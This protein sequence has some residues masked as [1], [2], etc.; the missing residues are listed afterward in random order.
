MKIRVAM[1]ALACVAIAGSVSA[2]TKKPVASKGALYDVTVTADQVYTGTMEMTIAGGKVAGTMTLTSPTTITGNVAGT[3]KAGTLSLD[4]PYRMTE[5]NC[6]GNV[7]MTIK[8]P[9]KPG[10]ASGTMEAGECG[11]NPDNKT[12][13]TVDL[14]PAVPAKK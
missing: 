1:A 7:K 13:G 4:F 9:A 10:P 11:G 5:R 8:M 12:T 3:S 14:K 6:E 2:Q